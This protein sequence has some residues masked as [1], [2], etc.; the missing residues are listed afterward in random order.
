MDERT[1]RATQ[2][3][4]AFMR[5]LDELGYWLGDCRALENPLFT[6]LFFLPEDGSGVLDVW[7]RDKRRVLSLVMSNP[8]A[9]PTIVSFEQGAWEQRALALDR[10]N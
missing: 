3:C 7:T 2:L 1:K 10:G 6:A 4:G 8:E 5:L 9:E